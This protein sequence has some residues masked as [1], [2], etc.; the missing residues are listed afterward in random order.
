MSWN[1]LLRFRVS[2]TSSSQLALSL[3]FLTDV[4]NHCALEA[5]SAHFL[6]CRFL[7]ENPDMMKKCFTLLG[8]WLS[9]VKS[10]HTDNLLYVHL[11]AVYDCIL[12][13]FI[14]SVLYLLY[15]NTMSMLKSCSGFR[16]LELPLFWF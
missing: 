4:V 1:M 6:L 7:Q 14:L 16:N 11:C 2:P 12:H 9:S 3:V 8:K 15:E 5:Q 13:L 10:Q